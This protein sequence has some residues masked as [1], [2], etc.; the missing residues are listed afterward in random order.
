MST[1]VNKDLGLKSAAVLTIK[2]PGEMHE[3]G[4]KDVAAWMRK[5]ADFFEQYGEQYSNRQFTAR[6]LYQEGA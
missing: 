3:Q 1:Q 5:Q 4:R 2:E 6:Y